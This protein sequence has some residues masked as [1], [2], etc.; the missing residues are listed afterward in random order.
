MSTN[1]PRR[2]WRE[3]VEP[4]LYR[5]HRLVCPRSEDHKPGGRCRCPYSL[6]VPDAVAGT[7]M[8]THPGPIADA[9]AERRR[10]MAAGR[11]A[12]ARK[13]AR[14]GD[15]ATVRDLARTYL[16]A[17][18]GALAASTLRAHDE[19][20]RRS[21]DGPLGR[22]LLSDLTRS[23][24]VAW[25]G[26]V[27]RTHSRHGVWK[28]H[29][30]LRTFC[31]WAVEQGLMAENPAAGVRLPGA[32]DGEA[33]TGAHRFLTLDQLRTLY[34]VLDLRTECMVRVSAECG[35]RRGEVVGLRWGDVDLSAG[36][37]TV[38]R[39]VVQESGRGKGARRSTKPPKSGR[40][41]VVA[42]PPSLAP[43]LADWYAE[44][45]VG[46]GAPADGY[47]F[48][49]HSGGLMGIYSPNQVLGR[50]CVR[51]GL[52]DDA[53]RPLVSWHGL[54]HTAAT[55]MLGAGIPVTDVQAQC[56]HADPSIT[57]RVYGHALGI[58]AQHAAAAVF[59]RPEKAQE[60]GQQPTS[61]TTA[62]VRDRVREVD[63]ADPNA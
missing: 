19:A 63:H 39:S 9:R 17:H 47:V 31:R 25:L 5:I 57:L 3:T 29:T 23:R 21:I 51:A 53:G 62:E 4:G 54:R 49:G 38:A 12:L 1:A 48:P 18:D 14:T 56:R 34:A 43:R 46:K 7:R 52:V 33:R 10:L 37:I 40:V 11:P 61:E 50:A 2:G 41:G 28:A 15:V 30:A 35:L 55:T 8:V 60:T 16:R 6:K 58:D 27:A 42:M 22:L 13:P 24:V 45:V 32:G 20:Y 44:S 59:D 26:E 36:R